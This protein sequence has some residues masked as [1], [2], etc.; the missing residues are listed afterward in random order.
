MVFY[1][2]EIIYELLKHLLSEN[3][4]QIAVGDM[5]GTKACCCIS[6]PDHYF[7]IFSSFSFSLIRGC[8][9]AQHTFLKGWEL[10]FSKAFMDLEHS[11][12]CNKM[13]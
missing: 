11:S 2:G 13:C 10:I 3:S 8:G 9:G 1:T 12:Q 4:S 5:R 7:S 6:V